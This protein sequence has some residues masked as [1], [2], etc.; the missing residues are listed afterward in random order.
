MLIF[1]W[2]SNC[3]SLAPK[4]LGQTKWTARQ[5]DKALQVRSCR[6]AEPNFTTSSRLKTT[7]E[8][9]ASHE[10]RKNSEQPQGSMRLPF[11][12]CCNWSGFKV[13]D[14]IWR[15]ACYPRQSRAFQS[16]IFNS[17][18]RCTSLAATEKLAT[19][20]GQ[21][22]LPDLSTIQMSFH[23]AS[24]AMPKQMLC[25]ALRGLLV[26]SCQPQFVQPSTTRHWHV[27]CSPQPG[28]VCE[29]ETCCIV[30]F[31]TFPLSFYL[32]LILNCCYVVVFGFLIQRS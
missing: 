18:W 4:V 15:L 27:P 13:K 11:R 31:V 21:C 6:R 20:G 23:A 29:E 28:F 32:A 22:R 12:G 14:Q 24:N 25:S 16:S 19:T 3:V 7:I 10:V 26:L 2:T 30:D 9:V 5:A 1:P 17:N 8:I